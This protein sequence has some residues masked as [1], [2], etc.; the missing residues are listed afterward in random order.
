M[1]NLFAI[2]SLLCFSVMFASQTSLDVGKDVIKQKTELSQ[3]A[4]EPI[5]YA[6]VQVIEVSVPTKGIESITS[7]EKEKDILP[8]KIHPIKEFEMPDLR[9]RGQD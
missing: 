2:L 1:K 3:V 7:T 5:Q 8:E 9:I 4:A 6:A